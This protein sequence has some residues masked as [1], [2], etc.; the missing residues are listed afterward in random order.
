[1]RTASFIG[2]VEIQPGGS[3]ELLQL[4]FALRA[5]KRADPGDLL[6]SLF[7][8]RGILGRLALLSR[9]TA[10]KNPDGQGNEDREPNSWHGR[11]RS[12]PL[13]AHGLRTNTLLLRSR[14]QLTQ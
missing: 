11:I 6:G 2:A 4:R 14:Y 3:L 13:N 12:K 5:V 9:L 10:G 8:D 1:M 7:I